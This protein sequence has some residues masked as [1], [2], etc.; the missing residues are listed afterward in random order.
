MTTVA[1]ARANVI[2]LRHS[3]DVQ[4]VE[5][6]LDVLIQAVR[7]DERETCA[8]QLEGQYGNDEART[9]VVDACV[10]HIRTHGAGEGA[11]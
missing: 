5:A 2:A 11:T 7:S 8:R 6:A 9:L 3:R 10:K 1:A 4:L